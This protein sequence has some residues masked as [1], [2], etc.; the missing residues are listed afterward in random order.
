MSYLAGRQSGLTM[1]EVLVTLFVFTVGLL[2]LAGLQLGA[3]KST[4][5]SNQ[6]TQAVWVLQ[7][8]AERMRANNLP[9]AD[10]G[11]T[12]A[13]NCSALPSPWC[14]DHYNP[15]SKS[16][17]NAVSCNAE[18]MAA[19]DRWEAECSYA[20]T[21]SYTANTTA[22]AGRYSSNDFLLSPGT[23]ARLNVVENDDLFTLTSRWRSKG[24]DAKQQSSDSVLSAGL[25]VRR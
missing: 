3:L 21:T 24:D 4:S 15:I 1:I 17:V 6:R 11:Y 7:E 14:A 18:Q 20:A 23:G 13:P 5:D 19:F 10:A 16:K 8:L 12:A 22:A 9:A 2:G 25:E